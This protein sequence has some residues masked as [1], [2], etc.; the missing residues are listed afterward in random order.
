MNKILKALLAVLIRVRRS[1]I[2]V[3]GSKHY[4]YQEDS[5]LVTG[6]VDG[7]IVETFG[8]VEEAVDH[9]SETS[10]ISDVEVL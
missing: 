7:E 8:S 2:V 9:I 4:E 5:G 1:V 10:H 3:G 6:V